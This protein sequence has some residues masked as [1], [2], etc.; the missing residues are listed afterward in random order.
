MIVH[1]V[2]RVAL[3]KRRPPSPIESV[4]VVRGLIKEV[5]VLRR[6]GGSVGLLFLLSIKAGKMDR[7]EP[8]TYVWR[9]ESV[10]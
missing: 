10:P 9:A 5:R 2:C 8:M 4:L 7:S 1:G 6:T 3:G